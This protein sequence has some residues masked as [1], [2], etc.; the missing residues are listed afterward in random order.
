MNIVEFGS[1]P[2]YTGT[3]GNGDQL[4]VQHYNELYR[5][6][7]DTLTS[8]FIK[9]NAAAP[10]ANTDAYGS[11]SDIAIT[12]DGAFIRLASGWHKL[13]SYTSD[14]GDLTTDVRFLPIDHSI[15]L[16]TAEL[17][18]VSTTLGL[19]L[20]STTRT[21][22]VKAGVSTAD[23]TGV[24]V[25]NNGAMTVRI[26]SE[27]IPGT[28]RLPAGYSEPIVATVD[29]VDSRIS[30]TT[31]GITIPVATSDTLGG[32]L[33]GGDI[34]VNGN[35]TATVIRAATDS[36]SYGIVRL[37]NDV[38][39]D[40]DEF[41]PI[42]SQVKEVVTNTVAESINNPPE[43]A[44]RDTPGLVIPGSTL[45]LG[46]DGSI[47]ANHAI[48]NGAAGIV[49]VTTDLT[50]TGTYIPTCEAVR[51][52]IAQALEDYTT[53]ELP[54]ATATS[55]GVIQGSSTIGIDLN[56]VASVP[57]A[58]ASMR[59]AVKLESVTGETNGDRAV[60]RGVVSDMLTSVVPSLATGEIAGITT[61]SLG[62]NED[63][64][65]NYPAVTE[66]YVQD[67]I[68][69]IALPPIDSTPI[70]NSP[71]LV[72]SGGVYSAISTASPSTNE[73]IVDVS[74]GKATA[75]NGGCVIFDLSN[76]TDAPES[77]DITLLF[78]V[79]T[80]PENFTMIVAI[81]STTSNGVNTRFYGTDGLDGV[82][83]GG[84]PGIKSGFLTVFGPYYS[85]R[86]I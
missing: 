76:W 19:G 54:I 5:A 50:S 59:G 6:E 72:T 35:G 81:A 62:T 66:G 52:G 20:A 21:G 10:A 73:Q 56:G 31:G 75:I 47:N 57:T 45:S 55:R 84:T 78:D 27:S 49:S 9:L 14:W 4:L 37:C 70:A 15:N 25:D 41:C 30:S 64:T 71:N 39:S 42:L 13:V 2:T 40:S 11:A 67:A 28:V 53:G 36:M 18:N 34:L 48:T 58:T 79:A 26:A 65:I 82:S 3:I 44:T 29:Y 74:T 38:T 8:R 80:L 69:T 24:D 1:L 63:P 32:I 22:T 51:E 60:T 46:T 86:A 16:S 68:S 7:V 61:L 33:S 83:L 77:E 85:Y 23:K 17:N 43:I 12:D